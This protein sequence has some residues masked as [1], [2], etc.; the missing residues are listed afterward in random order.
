MGEGTG[1]GL[2]ICYGIVRDH[3]G[4]IAVSSKVQVGTTFSILLPA[5]IDPPAE[6]DAGV[7]VA[8][9]DQTDR[10]FISAALAAWGYSVTS[11]DRADEALARYR[12]GDLRAAFV[13]RRILAA[14]LD[15]WR[16]EQSPD[17]VP[18]PIVVM[19]MAADER[20]VEQFG[21]EQASAVLVPPFQLRAL[22]CRAGGGDS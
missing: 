13:D 17:A 16:A 2:S 19:S 9:V 15:G 14:N 6:S 4:Q 5:R 20:E 11:T 1:L 8:H 10:D 3:G 21:H 7:L 12:S 22:R 18:V